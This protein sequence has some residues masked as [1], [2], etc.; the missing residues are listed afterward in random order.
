MTKLF[1]IQWM[2]VFFGV[3]C[4]GSV[5]L[6]SIFIGTIKM[7]AV[8]LC[9]CDCA[10]PQL[11]KT[12]PKS[13]CDEATKPNSLIVS[14]ENSDDEYSDADPLLRDANVADD[15]NSSHDGETATATSGVKTKLGKKIKKVRSQ[16]ILFR[17]TVKDTSSQAASKVKAGVVMGVEQVKFGVMSMKEFCGAGEIA[18]TVSIMSVNTDVDSE[19]TSTHISKVTTF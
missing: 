12:H 14:T 15:R 11:K 18:Q 6:L 9:K 10:Q 16:V 1:E 5:L 17:E 2:C 4:A 3:V 7:C 8:H 19:K 13:Q